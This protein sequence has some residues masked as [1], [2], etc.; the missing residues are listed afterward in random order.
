MDQ[1]PPT[2]P[3][4][5]PTT[6]ARDRSNLSALTRCSVGNR[7]TVPRQMPSGAPKNRRKP[8]RSG[9]RVRTVSNIIVDPGNEDTNSDPMAARQS[10]QNSSANARPHKKPAPGGLARRAAIRQNIN[11]KPQPGDRPATGVTKPTRLKRA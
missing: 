6:A 3:D 7:F 10:S 1:P 11:P 4:S 9:K 2:I 8:T 5:P